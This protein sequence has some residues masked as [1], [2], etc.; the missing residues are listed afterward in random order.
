MTSRN[1][2]PLSTQPVALPK[3]T[4]LQMLSP[5]QRDEKTLNHQREPRA[6]CAYGYWTNTLSSY[7]LWDLGC[8]YENKSVLFPCLD[9]RT[10]THALCRNLHTQ[11]ANSTSSLRK[12]QIKLFVVSHDVLQS[13]VHKF[14][15]NPQVLQSHVSF[16]LRIFTLMLTFKGVSIL[17]KPGCSCLPLKA[18]CY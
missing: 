12:V 3:P 8:M 15:G 4:M 17:S 13:E 16:S 7:H 6:G 11:V 1:K 2:I 14:A 9:L 5:L 10:E 18:W